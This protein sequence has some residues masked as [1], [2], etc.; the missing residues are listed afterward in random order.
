MYQLTQHKI[1]YSLTIPLS[2][3]TPIELPQDWYTCLRA[4]N[5]FLVMG[6][7]RSTRLSQAIPGYTFTLAPIFASKRKY[8]F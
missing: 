8:M 3:T 6:F 7:N 4:T 1:P 2:A 5:S